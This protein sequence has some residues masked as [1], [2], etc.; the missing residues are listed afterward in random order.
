VWH[1]PRTNVLL[2]ALVAAVTGLALAAW[3]VLTTKPEP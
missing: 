3:Y 1:W 2:G